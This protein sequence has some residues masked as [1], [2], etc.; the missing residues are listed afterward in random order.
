MVWDG[1]QD[2]KGEG[3]IGLP[4]IELCYQGPK[5]GKRRGKMR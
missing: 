4:E 1:E 3:G 5:F 2:V